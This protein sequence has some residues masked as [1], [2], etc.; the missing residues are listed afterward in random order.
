MTDNQALIDKL[1]NLDGISTHERAQLIALLNTKKRYGLI[2][3]DKPEA[4]EQLLQT[5]L[6][7]LTEVVER[8]IRPL[9]PEGGIKK[10]TD[11]W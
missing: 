10:L 8:K 2:W 3:E 1:K 4:A 9:P 6:P 7:V 5:Q 11:V